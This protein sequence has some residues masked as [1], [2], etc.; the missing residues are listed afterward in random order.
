MRLL[1]LGFNVNHI[2]GRLCESASRSLGCWLD[3]GHCG[4][5][6]SVVNLLHRQLLPGLVTHGLL[7]PAKLLLVL[8]QYLRRVHVFL[9]GCWLGGLAR[10]CWLDLF[11]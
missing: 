2:E 8:P 4:L 7:H 9:V 6:D 3:N 1:R 5:L 10:G 11:G